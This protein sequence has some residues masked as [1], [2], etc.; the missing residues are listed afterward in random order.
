M[1]DVISG[2]NWK[3]S[4]KHRGK[5]RASEFIRNSAKRFLTDE[6]PVPSAKRTRVQ[7]RN[8][9]SSMK[10]RMGRRSNFNKMPRRVT[11]AGRKVSRQFQRRLPK[12]AVARLAKK[13]GISKFAGKAVG[14]IGKKAISKV[15]KSLLST[16]GISAAK[17]F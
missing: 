2:R 7:S 4:M 12:R 16:I 13:S 5:E 17:L 8:R 1:S 6:E 15:G 14:R 10:S 11:K 3:Q 9:S